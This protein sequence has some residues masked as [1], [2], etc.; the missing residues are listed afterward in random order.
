MSTNRSFWQDKP[1]GSGSIR[2]SPIPSPSR[3]ADDQLLVKV[4]AWALNPADPMVQDTALPFITCP[5]ILGEDIAGTVLAV[6]SAAGG[7]FSV[8]DRV[9]GFGSGN[10][11]PEQ[12][13]FQ[14]YVVLS[15]ASACKIPNDMSFSEGVVFP[16]CISTAACALFKKMYLGLPFP[17]I[18]APSTGKT[19]LVWGGSSGVGSNAIQLTKSVGFEVI[20]TCSAKNFEY[21]KSLGATKVF[22]YN[23]PSVIEDIVAELDSGTCAGIF[24][25]AGDVKPSLNVSYKS[26]QKLF[27]ASATIVPDGAAPDGVEAKMVF[28]TSGDDFMNIYGDILPATFGGF[29]PDALANGV[30]KVAPVPEVQPTRGVE[31]IQKALD[32]LKKGVSAK[33]IVVVAE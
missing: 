9:I 19:L 1:G 8:G 21:V 5:L 20:A 10:G 27:V 11:K 32:V 17:Q 25:T 24:H 28:G 2:S 31:G 23:S 16:L 18:D 26:K 7:K 33:K 12:G 13:A 6:G 4:R 29:L 30:Y 22:D 14:E 15:Y 3:L